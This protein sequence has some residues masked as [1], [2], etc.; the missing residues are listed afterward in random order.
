MATI[1]AHVAFE[2]DRPVTDVLR[3]RRAYHRWLRFAVVW[4]ARDL[5]RITLDEIGEALGRSLSAAAKMSRQAEVIHAADV[6]FRNLIAVVTSTLPRR[7]L[8]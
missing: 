6:E 4:L 8:P 7:V 5:G 1:A 3:P 2:A